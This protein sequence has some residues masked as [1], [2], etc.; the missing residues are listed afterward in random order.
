MII[1]DKIKLLG[2][3]HLGRSF[4]NNVPLHRR[5]HREKMVWDHFIKELDPQGATHHIHMGDLFDK[6]V[7]NL[8]VILETALAYRLVARAHDQTSFYILQGNHDASRD[9]QQTTAFQVFAELVSTISNILVVRE[10]VVIDGM[11]LIPWDPLISADDRMIDLPPCHTVF[12][13]WDCDPRSDP[14]NLIPTQQLGNA[15]VTHAFT[16][17]VHKPDELQRNGVNVA[18][19]G[20]MQ[21]FSFGEQINDDIYIDLTLEEAST[22]TDLVNKCVRVQLQPGEVF[23]LS[24]DCLQLQ[25]K[26]ADEDAGEAIDVSLGDFSL[27]NVFEETLGEFAM[28][29]NV[30]KLLRD[31]WSTIFA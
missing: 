2:D 23:D 4:V 16:G 26:K 14:F 5:G 10:P 19:V 22:R 7:V 17:H 31:K 6:P 24:I 12:G 29:V 18:V 25:L 13:H 3:S 30:E 9:L 20:S 11:G 27:N 15:G 28:P 21:P 1:D 8:K